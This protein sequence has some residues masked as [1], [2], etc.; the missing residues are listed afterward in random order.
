MDD[1]E[2]HVSDL[3]LWKPNQPLNQTK[4][5]PQQISIS[6][7]TIQ[8][9]T[10]KQTELL[11]VFN[12]QEGEMLLITFYNHS[13]FKGMNAIGAEICGMVEES[14]LNLSQKSERATNI[15]TEKSYCFKASNSGESIFSVIADGYRIE[16][17]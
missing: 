12:D 6:K 5:N 10:C 13:A 8:Q 3:N 16:K 11:V 9:V 2:R 4:Q 15:K 17:I 14:D 1:I 7:G